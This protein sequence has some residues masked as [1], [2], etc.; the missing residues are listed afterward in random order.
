MG[1]PI[2]EVRAEH[3]VKAAEVRLVAQAAGLGTL[4]AR[5]TSLIGWSAASMA[6]LIA[7][8]VAGGSAPELRAAAGFGAVALALAAR[9]ALRCL[10]P[11]EWVM[12][13]HLP[14]IVLNPRDGETAAEF[15]ESLAEGYEPGI[16]RNSARL[17]AASDALTR[18][19]RLLL[20]APVA[21]LLGGGLCRLLIWQIGD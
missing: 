13:G 5:A 7:V 20:L 15:H 9:Q 12:P 19:L 3:A 18:A 2:E 6:G 17:G 16:R 14:Q 8:A 21:A 1:K 11:G 4:E 10:V